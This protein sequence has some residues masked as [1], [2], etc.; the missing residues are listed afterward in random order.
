MSLNI[1]HNYRQ[2]EPTIVCIPTLWQQIEIIFFKSIEVFI[3]ISYIF[4]VQ[5]HVHGKKF[6]CKLCP[7]GFRSRSDLKTHT[8]THTGEKPHR[9]EYCGTGFSQKHNLKMH[10]SKQ[11]SL[12][13][14]YP[15]NVCSKSFKYKLDLKR[16]LC[17]HNQ[18]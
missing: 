13:N 12:D 18:M 3:R 10:L 4:L 17:E 16:H 1:Q 15:C 6:Q 8:Y 5:Q 14:I 2:W 11:H 7:K 9:C